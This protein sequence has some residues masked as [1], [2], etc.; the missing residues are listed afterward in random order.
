MTMIFGCGPLFS[1]MQFMSGAEVISAIVDPDA[2]RHN[3]TTFAFKNKLGG[4]IAVMALNSDDAV[5]GFF[6]PV[7]RELLHNLVNWMSCGKPDLLVMK[8]SGDVNY[9]EPLILMLN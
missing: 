2:K 1:R 5:G 8:Y 7:R 4:R 3:P 6:N 9:L